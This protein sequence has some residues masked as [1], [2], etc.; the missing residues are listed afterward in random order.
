M[1]ACMRMTHQECCKH[2][3]SADRWLEQVCRL[4]YVRIYVFQEW[5]I[6]PEVNWLAIYVSW[7]DWQDDAR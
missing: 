3:W 1:H 5:V 2:A 4:L 7:S 6:T